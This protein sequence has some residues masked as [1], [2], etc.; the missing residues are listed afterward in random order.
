L[1]DLRHAVSAERARTLSDVLLRRV[2]MGWDCRF[3]DDE[4]ARAA[5]VVGSELGW[6]DTRKANEIAAFQAEISH[7]F[8]PQAALR[9]RVGE[10]LQ[11]MASTQR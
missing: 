6:D 10:S 11:S 2:G 8:R 4:L 7:L 1:S 5:D 3:S 9:P